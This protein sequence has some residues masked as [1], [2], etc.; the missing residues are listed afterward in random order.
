MGGCKS[1]E[2]NGDKEKGQMNKKER[3]NRRDEKKAGTGTNTGF[4][5]YNIIHKRHSADQKVP[6]CEHL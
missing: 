3:A 5:S 2:R 1:G 6:Q 4:R